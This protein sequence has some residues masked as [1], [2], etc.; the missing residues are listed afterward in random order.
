MRPVQFSSAYIV[1][2]HD[3][4][5]NYSVAL[6]DDA[7]EGEGHKIYLDGQEIQDEAV[8][9]LATLSFDLLFER[10]LKKQIAD[11]VVMN[12]LRKLSAFEGA[13][14]NLSA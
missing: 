9:G 12:R 2:V 10:Y 5:N 4:P 6:L 14:L 8:N 7:I 3:N 11:T 13:T 1:S